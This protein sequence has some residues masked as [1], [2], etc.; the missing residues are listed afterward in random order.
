MTE[1]GAFTSQV[2]T[3]TLYA[4]LGSL[5]GYCCYQLVLPS[6]CRSFLALRETLFGCG[7]AQS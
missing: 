2:L 4:S 1:G 7:D 5:G 6:L 3:V